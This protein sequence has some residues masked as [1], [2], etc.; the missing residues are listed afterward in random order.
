MAGDEHPLRIDA[1]RQKARIADAPP[2]NG[3]RNRSKAVIFSAILA[4]QCGQFGDRVPPTSGT[5]AL[6]DCSARAN[7]RHSGSSS[8]AATGLTLGVG[9]RPVTD[10]LARHGSIPKRDVTKHRAHKI[11]E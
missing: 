11:N 10:R 4:L 3:P 1:V 5:A 2:V 9:H 8:G 7:D 6:V